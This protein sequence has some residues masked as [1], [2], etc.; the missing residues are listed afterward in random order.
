MKDI[1]R[2]QHLPY[3]YNDSNSVCSLRDQQ[4]GLDPDPSG[5]IVPLSVVVPLRWGLTLL[6]T[7]ESLY[8]KVSRLLLGK[9][10]ENVDN[11]YENDEDQE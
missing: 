1:D 11:N 7:E 5:L 9:T 3:F 6:L 10:V 4:N 8:Q 2:K